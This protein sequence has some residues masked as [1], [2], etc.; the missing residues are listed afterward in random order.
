MDNKAQLSNAPGP[1]SPVANQPAADSAPAGLSSGSVFLLHCAGFIAVLAVA[2]WLRRMPVTADP[3]LHGYLQMT[4]GLLALVFAAV[5]L[6]RFRG[7]R[8]RVALMLGFGF[9]L[10]GAMLVLSSVFFFQL[11]RPEPA[12]ALWA[13]LAW[14]TSRM[15]LALLLVVTFFVDWHF[16]RT[17]HPQGE[18]AGALLAVIVLTY[19]MSSAVERLWELGLT[20]SGTIIPGPQQLIPAVLLLYALVEARLR[21]IYADSAFDH[22]LYAFV[23]LNF[24]AQLAATQS[25]RLLDSPFL[26]VQCLQLGGYAVL[27]GGALLDNARLFEQVHHL[28]ASDPLTGLANYRRLVDVLENE[29][30]RTNRTGRPFAVLLLDMDGLKKINDTYGHLTGT[31]AIM[32]QADVLRV[33]SRSMDTAARYGGDEFAL[34]LPESGE[35]EAQHVAERIREAM[36][37][38]TEQPAIGASI[39]ISVYEPDGERIQKLLLNAD[40]KLYKE[41]ARRKTGR[42]DE[43]A[44]G[45]PAEPRS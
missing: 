13:P 3:M 40:K 41:K 30:E 23:W 37:N 5:S 31:R 39:G 16:P 17:R 19:M 15:L 29:T 35:A 22:A 14:W 42:T 36:K 1:Q 8:D 24:A 21:R 9:L 2:A 45:R 43:V 34:V 26:L 44:A 10:S 6:V 12:Q 20:P 38:D 4:A 18:S 33:Q 28:A 11:L 27:L 7:A 25:E 32:R